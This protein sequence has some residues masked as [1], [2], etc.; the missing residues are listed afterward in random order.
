MS[1][2]D[3]FTYVPDWTVPHLTLFFFFFFFF[4]KF[5][6][7]DFLKGE[8]KQAVYLEVE[9]PVHSTPDMILDK[10]GGVEVFCSVYT[11]PMDSDYVLRQGFRR[12]PNV[13]FGSLWKR[14]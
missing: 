12:L 7:V 13:I 11:R 2:H 5:Y 8:K 9:L 6:S 10:G 14:F 1:G 4:K 3:L